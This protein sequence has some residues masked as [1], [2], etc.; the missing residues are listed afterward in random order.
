MGKTLK[1]V[2]FVLV[3]SYL[4]VL[5]ATL[6]G[7]KPSTLDPAKILPLI[8]LAIPL[9][10]SKKAKPF[11]LLPSFKRGV[12]GG[13]IGGFIAGVSI[14][15]GYYLNYPTS[16]A[17]PLHWSIIPEIVLYAS[18]FVGAIIAGATLYL[19]YRF[20]YEVEEKDYPSSIFNDLTGGAIAG[21]IGGALVG[22]IGGYWFGT[23]PEDPVESELLVWGAVAGPICVVFGALRYD[24][25][26]N[27]RNLWRAFFVSV[28]AA[29]VL[30]VFGVFL[31]DRYDMR[32]FLL[33][34]ATREL[35][36]K[37]GA[38]LGAAVGLILGLQTGLALLLYRIMEVRQETELLNPA[39]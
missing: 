9:L 26:G 19:V 38:Y 17:A 22:A 3:L 11:H 23:R 37:G 24:F 8:G 21:I 1:A 30:G 14:G 32:S 7:L 29:I 25:H 12:Y 10:E 2:L 36:I 6:S 35:A 16:A 34:G 13:L 5:I 27:L 31:V 4:L 15:V 39:P 20:R 28:L 18:L 33:M